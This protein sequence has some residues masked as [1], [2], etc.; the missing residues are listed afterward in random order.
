MTQASK[1]QDSPVRSAIWRAEPIRNPVGIPFLGDDRDMSQVVPGKRVGDSEL[2]FPFP[3][4]QEE[5]SHTSQGCEGNTARELPA[6][7]RPFH[8]Q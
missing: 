4:Q 2:L 8:G 5:L 6:E 1:R 7:R 3:I